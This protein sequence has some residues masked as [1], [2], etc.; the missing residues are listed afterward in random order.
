MSNSCFLCFWFLI[1]DY[2]SYDQISRISIGSVYSELF[3]LITNGTASAQAI[4]YN[5]YTHI[6]KKKKSGSI[7]LW[8]THSSGRASGESAKSNMGGNL[9]WWHH[10]NEGAAKSQYPLVHFVLF[11]AR[12][13]WH[14]CQYS[15]LPRYWFKTQ[16]LLLNIYS[17]NIAR[18]SCLF[19]ITILFFLIHFFNGNP[20]I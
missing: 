16:A 8:F 4:I 14:Y 10:V 13:L 20:C 18:N 17:N 2:S 7:V 6:F 15:F 3:F 12:L 11:L 19:C 1:L 5:K 9:L